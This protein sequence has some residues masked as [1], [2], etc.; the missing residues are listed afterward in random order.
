[1]S[2]LSLLTLNTSSLK[3]RNRM[4]MLESYLLEHGSPDVVLLQETGTTNIFIPNYVT[5]GD[6]VGI[7]PYGQ[8][9]RIRTAVLVREGRFRACSR[10]NPQLSELP[11][12]VLC[13]S[14]GDKI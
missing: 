5:Y 1:M 9:R 4:A 7:V 3:R 10:I 8:R 12:Y 11:P 13:S 2:E 14:S 6:E